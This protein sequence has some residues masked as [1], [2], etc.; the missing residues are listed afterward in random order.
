M[1]ILRDLGLPAPW[2]EIIMAVF[3]G[4][5]L[6][7]AL[8]GFS[9]GKDRSV[10][11]T[12]VQLILWSG[13]V[14]GSY[15]GMAALNGNFLGDIPNNLI[16]LMGISAGSAVTAISTRRLQSGDKVPYNGPQR[17][18]GMLS[19]ESDPE[20]LSLPKLQ[21]FFWTIVAIL[22]Y[23]VIIG[24]NF[25]SGKAALPDP[26][27]G[28]VALMGISH[29]AYLG[30]KFSDTPKEGEQQVDQFTVSSAS[31]LLTQQISVLQGRADL[32]SLLGVVKKDKLIAINDPGF[33]SLALEAGDILLAY[34][35]SMKLAQLA[36][37]A[38]AS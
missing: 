13:V 38:G 28:L 14:I 21:M 3:S 7:I 1:M 15:A 33:P 4:A 2:P 29:G 6:I 12:N 17:T 26:G 22:I 27:T 8:L 25:S 9:R 24:S 5:F 23:L 35:N 10:S 32:P 18:W 11:L 30:N 36:K 37:L 19:S 16:A 31:L 20:Q 34:G